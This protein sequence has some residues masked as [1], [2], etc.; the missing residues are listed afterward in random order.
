MSKIYILSLARLVSIIAIGQ[1]QSTEYKTH[2]LG[3]LMLRRALQNPEYA[4]SDKLKDIT[5]IG[6][7]QAIRSRV[8]KYGG[9]MKYN[10]GRISSVSIPYKNLIAF[11]ESPA[12]LQ[13]ETSE[14]FNKGHSFMDTARIN[15][16]IR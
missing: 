3:G 2:K 13:I 15:N 11:S 8:A 14:G 7:A 1:A 10:S 9:V 6:D 12:V 5:I 4:H 16:N